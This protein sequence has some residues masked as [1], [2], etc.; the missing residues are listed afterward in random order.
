M[1]ADTG[2]TRK[3]SAPPPRNGSQYVLKDRGSLLVISRR[4]S[5]LPPAHFRKGAALPGDAAGAPANNA[6][7]V[8][9]VAGGNG[10]DQLGSLIRRA[11]ESRQWEGK[12]VGVKFW[13]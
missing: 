3:K 10:V 4:S 6:S 1:T 2:E 9:W 5:V 8:L 11:L 7:F 13:S 12:G